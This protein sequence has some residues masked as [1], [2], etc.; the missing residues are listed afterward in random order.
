M[1]FIAD[2]L[3]VAGAVGA[4]AFCL[5]LS[6][7]LRRFSQ[8][9]N[10]MGGAIAVLSSQV[11]EMTAAL[12][13]AQATA[14]VSAE[15][16]GSLTLRAEQSARRIEL[17]LASLHD[18]PEGTDLAGGSRTRVLRSRRAMPLSLRGEAQPQSEALG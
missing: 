5:V 7:R 1:Q 13:R 18:L 9:D 12:S 17:L 15:T 10:G 4:A 3:L 6:R 8:L 11:D 14:A 2:I 16:L